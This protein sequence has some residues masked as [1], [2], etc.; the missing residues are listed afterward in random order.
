MKVWVEKKFGTSFAHAKAE[1]S[2]SKTSEKLAGSIELKTKPDNSKPIKVSKLTIPMHKHKHYREKP[3]SK[4][5][6]LK[7]LES[8][9]G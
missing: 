8:L 9:E 6:S 7:S 1:L 4:T 2:Q 5:F 3:V